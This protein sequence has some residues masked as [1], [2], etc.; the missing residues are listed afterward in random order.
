MKRISFA[1]LLCT[2]PLM[3]PSSAYAQ[4][5]WDRQHAELVIMEGRG[6]VS[7]AP[8]IVTGYSQKITPDLTTQFDSDTGTLTRELKVHVQGATLLNYGWL[9]I[10]EDLQSSWKLWGGPES[11]TGYDGAVMHQRVDATGPNQLVASAIYHHDYRDPYIRKGLSPAPK[12]VGGSWKLIAPDRTHAAIHWE[13]KYGSS[14]GGNANFI[15]YHWGSF[16]IKRR[17]PNGQRQPAN[18]FEVWHSGL[19]LEYNYW[20][21]FG[22]FPGFPSVPMG[23]SVFYT[24]SPYGGDI[25]VDSFVPDGVDNG[26]VLELDIA[27]QSTQHNLGYVVIP[28]IE[29]TVVTGSEPNATASGETVVGWKLEVTATAQY[30]PPGSVGSGPGGGTGGTGGTGSTGGAGSNGGTGGTPPPGGLTFP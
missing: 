1:C 14:I 28:G 7:P 26:E 11:G 17:S 27:D 3:L 21:W 4:R 9:H 13:Y 23:D 29:G 16:S 6:G 24:V 10:N 2:A 25:V 15:S 5:I 8:P 19:T 20:K 22:G 18:A 12:V 30:S